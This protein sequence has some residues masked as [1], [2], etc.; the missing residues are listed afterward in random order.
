MT[1][2]P[3]RHQSQYEGSV[4]LVGHM[5]SL[6]GNNDEELLEIMVYHKQVEYGLS[7]SQVDIV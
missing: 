7:A 2:C 3:Y 4:V 6:W 5:R 1:R